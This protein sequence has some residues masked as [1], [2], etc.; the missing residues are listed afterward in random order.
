[1]VDHPI[2]DSQ[3]EI[4]QIKKELRERHRAPRPETETT[5]AAPLAVEQLAAEPPAAPQPRVHIVQKGDSLSQI[6]K[7]VYGDASRWR[8]IYEANKHQIKD[9][10]IIQP[11]QELRIP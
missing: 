1:M 10:K 3:E 5:E 9:P 11:G 7:A 6:S 4:E 2:S 8:E